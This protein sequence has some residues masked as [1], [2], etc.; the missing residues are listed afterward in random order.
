MRK[1][2]VVGF[3][4]SKDGHKDE[5]CVVLIRKN[6]PEWQK[7]FFNGIGGC[8]EKGESPEDAMKREFQEEAGM[9]IAEWN[10]VAV[11]YCPTIVLYFFRSFGNIYKVKAYNESLTDEEISLWPVS[12]LPFN[13]SCPS[14]WIASMCLNDDIKFPIEFNYGVDSHER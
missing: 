11:V 6:R 10:R 13:F 1:Q 12:Q 7:G 4:F 5:Q 14:N 8:I 9:L 2:Y 3:M